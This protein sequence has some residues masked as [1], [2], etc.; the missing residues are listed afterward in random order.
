MRRTELRPAQSVD[1]TE[2]A[3][4]QF[5]ARRA[6]PMPLPRLSVAEL[7]EVLAERLG[8]DHFTVA[9]VA[10]EVVG[11]ALFTETWLDDLY[12][13]PAHQGQGV[14]QLLL[15]HV[16][17]QLPGGFGLWAFETNIPARAFYARHGL[18]ELEWTDGS[19]NQEQEP[20]V[21]LAWPG[22]VPEPVGRHRPVGG[23]A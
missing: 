1:L 6:A 4:L 7:R 14:G 12:V 3:E 5:A 16:Q 17:Q 19:E 20:E 8:V 21:R 2:A 13:A 23:F 18:A 22:A 11:Y 10:G 9:D 15:T